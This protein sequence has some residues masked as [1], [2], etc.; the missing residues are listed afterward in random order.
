MTVSTASDGGRRSRL[1]LA[2][3]TATV[4]LILAGVVGSVLAADAAGRSEGDRN[5]KAFEA[6]SANVASTLEL[7]I[8]HDDDLVVDAGGLLADP[9]LSQTELA[10]WATAARVS[11]RT[12]SAG[13]AATSS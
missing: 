10:R 4:A 8:Q 12:P 13:W 2:W 5:R 7:A 1:Q 11:E 6:S 3:A 9:S